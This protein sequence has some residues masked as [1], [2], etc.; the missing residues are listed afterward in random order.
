MALGLDPVNLARL[1]QPIRVLCVDCE[2]SPAQ[3]QRAFARMLA[4]TGYAP[5][6]HLLVEVRPQGLD[7]LRSADQRWLTGLVAA[8]SPAVLTAGPLYKLFV[9]GTDDEGSARLVSQYL[10]RL[11]RRFGLAVVIE[12]HSPHGMAGDRA[13]LRPFGS[14]LWMRWP[15]FGFGLLQR[16]KRDMSKV[17]VV[18]WRGMRDTHRHFP[19][20]L[21]W[22]TTG[23]PW[24]AT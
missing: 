22:S 6:E 17:E 9:A 2:N 18:H 13:G 14:S 23:F 19:T 5:T 15:E 4:R 10:D 12:A 11:R 3:T 7:L 21:E 1:E 20:G 24:R 8:A 16:S